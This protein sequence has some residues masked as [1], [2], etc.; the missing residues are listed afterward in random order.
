MADILSMLV[1][2]QH[3]RFDDIAESWLAMGAT[4]FS[5]WENNQMLAHW[6]Q[7]HQIQPGE[8]VAPIVA[9][10]AILGELHVTGL[11]DPASVM[12]LKAEAGI[13]SYVSQLEYDLDM[14]TSELV[15][16][17]DQLLAIYKLT[18]SMHSQMTIDAMLNFSLLEALRMI[19]AQSGF[20][21]IVPTN[22]EA[23]L[24]QYPE[25]ILDEAALWRYFWQMHT[26]DREFVLISMHEQDKLLLPP[27]VSNVL[28]IP[29]NIRNTVAAGVGF[30]NKPEE[31]FSA[32]DIKLARAI[33]SQVSAQ[34]EMF[35]LYHETFEQA[36]LQSEMDLARRVQLNL[37]PQHLPMVTGLDLYATTRPAFKVGGDFYDVI[38]NEQRPFFFSV[39]D[40]T[41]KG[42][43][44]A[45][46]MTMALSAI[47]AKAS[48]MPNPTP[49]TIMRQSNEDLYN[50][51]TQLG[52][53]ATVFI[54]QYLPEQQQMV[55]A[56][57][58]HSPVIYRP[59]NT[60][61]RLLKA[62]STAIGIL[63]DIFCTNENIVFRPGDIL[64]VATDGFSEACN[65][66]ESMFG[67]DRMLDL[68]DEK[69]D[70]SAQ[71]IAEAL[72]SAVEQFRENHPQED[73]QTLIV[74]KG[75]AA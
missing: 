18:R 12:R 6:P 72:F 14:M 3:D 16:H 37:L 38:A 11:A 42:L 4:S 63:P 60:H 29:I 67:Y 70:R 27:G 15:Q 65:Q 28:F 43:S 5:I 2:S 66:Q 55:F 25:G 64:V 54:G 53:F 32:P 21:A 39:G 9:G 57:A 30:L 31:D 48:F 10:D 33:A 36:K 34:I 71:E 40:I 73:D 41:G 20:A 59:Y 58:G 69:A 49:E 35:L 74:L 44:A 51:F 19:G 45:L 61:A 68:I 23:L 26:R 52:V 8:L 7:H 46:L 13:I 75:V 62:A 22:Q 47:R 17:Q 56:N 1:N 50:N 24:V